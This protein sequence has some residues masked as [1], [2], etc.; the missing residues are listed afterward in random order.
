MEKPIMATSPITTRIKES[1]PRFWARIAGALY[2]IVIVGGAFAELFVR[3]RLV[4]SGDAAATAHNIFAHG[5][6]YRAGFAA[7]IFICACNV[8]LTLIEYYLFKIVNRNVALLM[9]TFAMIANTIEAVS[10]LAH[11]APLVFLGDAHYLSAFT[12]EQLQVSAYMSLRL[13]ETGFAICLI[14]FGFEFLAKTYLISKSNFFPRIIGLLLGIEGL[15]Y[16][17]NSFTLFLAPTLQA[18]IFPYF[19]LTGLAE[20][21]YCLWLLIMGVNEE[22]WKQQAST[23][24]V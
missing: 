9:A 21:A 1:S 19:M 8:P 6:L 7:E 12:T 2:L 10:L 13:F 3:G 18:R 23:A 20:V 14:F 11:Y 17:F 4:I 22:R 24:L 15:G 16:L 5:L